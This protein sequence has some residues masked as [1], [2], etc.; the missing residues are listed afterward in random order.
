M[1]TESNLPV[2]FKD[3][4]IYGYNYVKENMDRHGGVFVN[5]DNNTIY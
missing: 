3:N 4:I 1:I 5:P 2:C